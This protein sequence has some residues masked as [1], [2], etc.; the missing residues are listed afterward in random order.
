MGRLS[1][2]LLE[3]I[4]ELDNSTICDKC[5]TVLLSDDECYLEDETDKHLCTECCFYDE[6]LGAYIRGTIEDS[7]SR[8]RKEL[9]VLKCLDSIL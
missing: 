7:H 2:A 4:A 8:L 9:A 3:Q 1:N 5:S 6:Y